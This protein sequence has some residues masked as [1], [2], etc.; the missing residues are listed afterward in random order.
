MTEAAEEP[1]EIVDPRCGST[2][3]DRYRIVKRIGVGGMGV[4]YEGMHLLIQ[5][6]VAIKMLHA[7][8]TRNREIL[9]R[10]RREA[11]AATTIRH[12]HIV[13]VLD[14]GNAPDGAAYMVLEFLDGRDWAEDIEKGGAQP[15]G[16]TVRILRQVC[17]GL[18]A[19]HDKNIVH[20]DLKPEN[21]Y[22]SRHGSNDDFVKIVDFGISKMLDDAEAQ[23]SGK[24]QQA[25]TKTGA[26]MGTPY[27]MAPEQMMGQKDVDHRADLW[28]IGVILFRAL[29]ASYPF[30]ADTF[31][32]L[33]V[34]VLTGDPQPLS[35]FRT[36]LPPEVQAIVSRSL[37]KDRA[38]RYQSAKEIRDALAPFESFDTAPAPVQAASAF[39]MAATM[40]PATP[41]VGI[42]PPRIDPPGPAPVTTIGHRVTPP[43][44]ASTPPPEPKA[45]S[46][47]PTSPHTPTGSMA[48][49]PP[50]RAGSSVWTGAMLA[51]VLIALGGGGTVMAIRMLDHGD[52][53]PTIAATDVAPPPT[54]AAPPP[55]TTPVPTVRLQITT[56]PSSAELLFDGSPIPNPFDGDVPSS[57]EHHTILARAEG[58]AP[59]TRV[60]PMEFPMR[61]TIELA[62]E[63]GSHAHPPTTRTTSH[64]TAH[65]TAHA[66][67]PPST[68]TVVHVE[69]PVVHVEVTPPPTSTTPP[70][71]TTRSG[72]MSPFSSH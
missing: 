7:E 51:V 54:V 57:S 9:A 28:A 30:D 40:T 67:P 48:A 38:N 41:M 24:A 11:I 66:D 36:D 42:A 55:A 50:E 49:A 71:P 23:P 46:L 31:P 17:E 65:D 10:F 25:L 60:M 33:A 16:K 53:P 14:M 13:E 21:V 35:K 59:E 47:P 12:P 15:L 18:Q 32:L 39:V 62:R 52:P 72:L 19:A 4:V 8:Y 2:L 6:R 63:G 44:T 22:L 58:Y 70:P 5:R 69:T 64:D 61:V 68:T 43:E 27:A 34:S 1:F 45:A 29:T 37:E 26:A 56:V 20:R 3:N